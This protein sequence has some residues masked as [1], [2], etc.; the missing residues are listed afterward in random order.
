MKG[1]QLF[2]EEASN[3]TKSLQLNIDEQY[4]KLQHIQD[5]VNVI[6]S[7]QTSNT[8]TSRLDLLALKHSIGEIL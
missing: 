7:T 6:T 8:I 4:V 2:K 3:L 1:V 5:N